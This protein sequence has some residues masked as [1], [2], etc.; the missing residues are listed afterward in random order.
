MKASIETLSPLGFLVHVE[1][2]VSGIEALLKQLPDIEL[3][4]REAG[5]RPSVP[6]RTPDGL[7]ICEKHDEPMTEKQ[8][9]GDS[10]FSHKVVTDDGQELYC[11]GRSGKDSP[12]W[13]Y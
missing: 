9:Q 5:C 1:I 10:W 8:K 2:E 13:N 3:A 4:L 6:P 7:P 12:G 11:K